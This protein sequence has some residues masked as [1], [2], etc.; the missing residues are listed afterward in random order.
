M[1][2]WDSP[3][4]FGLQDRIQKKC[5][6]RDVGF[7]KPKRKKCAAK[8]KERNQAINEAFQEL[9][10]RIP[11]VSQKAPKIKILKLAKLY[12]ME[13]MNSLNSPE[14]CSEESISE[15]FLPK[16]VHE[17]QIKNCYTQRASEEINTTSSTSNAPSPPLDPGYGS[18]STETPGSSFS[19]S[20]ADFVETNNSQN[21]PLQY[22]GF[23]SNHNFCSSTVQYPVENSYFPRKQEFEIDYEF[24][25]KF[26]SFDYS[27]QYHTQQYWGME[28]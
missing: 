6:R 25:P 22:S 19:N 13:L 5:S 15:H 12:I 1:S 28:C 8:E 18:F 17:M 3:Y 27:N 23:N 20:P 16:V 21:Y 4:V 11:H 14:G 9:Q 2:H 7:Q 10:N 26:Q 24:K